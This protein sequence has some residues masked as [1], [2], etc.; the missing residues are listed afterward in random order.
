MPTSNLEPCRFCNALV[1]SARMERHVEDR[2]P[3]N[4]NP[5]SKRQMLSRKRKELAARREEIQ[6][7]L[8]ARGEAALP[9]V[10]K[11]MQPSQRKS[12]Y[13]YVQRLLR[14]PHEQ[15]EV[16]IAQLMKLLE[17]SQRQLV[18]RLVH[19]L[20]DENEMS[21]RRQANAVKQ[22]SRSRTSYPWRLLTQG[23][24]CNGR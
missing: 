19:K 22:I 7:K 12:V 2:C 6:I 13:V 5:N 3:K 1:S 9:K 15:Q 14:H 4:P 16:P 10:I 21:A 23:G 24:L 8:A 17:P 11:S 18:T 20:A